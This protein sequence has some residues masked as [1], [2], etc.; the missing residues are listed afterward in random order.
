MRIE[1]M[2]SRCAL[3]IGSRCWIWAPRR[4]GFSEAWRAYAYHIPTPWDY[5]GPSIAQIAVCLKQNKK[6]DAVDERTTLVDVSRPTM[7]SPRG[8]ISISVRVLR[9]RHETH[10]GCLILIRGVAHVYARRLLVSTSTLRF[11]LK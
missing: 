8:G 2:K 6:A 1:S 5:Q 3:E 10:Q 4:F 11:C 7:P 9:F